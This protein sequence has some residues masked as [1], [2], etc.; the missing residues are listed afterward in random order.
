M[1]NLSGFGRDRERLK[2]LMK[3]LDGWYAKQKALPLKERSCPM[4]LGTAFNKEHLESNLDSVMP[5]S[6]ACPLCWTLYG[7]HSFPTEREWEQRFEHIWKPLV[8][9]R[10]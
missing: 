5:A 7:R 4:C 1:S 3:D 6:Q 10:G 2:Q 9:T 8:Q